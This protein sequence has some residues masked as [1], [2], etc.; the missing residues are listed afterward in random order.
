MRREEVSEKLPAEL[1]RPFSHQRL[2]KVI[3]NRFLFPQRMA[4][5]HV[6][7][8]RPK[9]QRENLQNS[10]FVLVGTCFLVL[11]GLPRPSHPAGRAWVIHGTL[12]AFQSTP[13][14]LCPRSE[15]PQKF[16][17]ISGLC[18]AVSSASLGMCVFGNVHMFLHQFF[19]FPT[20]L[21][22]CGVRSYS[23]DIPVTPNIGHIKNICLFIWRLSSPISAVS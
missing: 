15:I 7:V 9:R 1:N 19:F 21:P 5:W 14:V 2:T 17:L 12:K 20:N 23:E 8:Y 3:L 6:C 18:N 11:S 16:V 22:G 10:C 4:P 13:L